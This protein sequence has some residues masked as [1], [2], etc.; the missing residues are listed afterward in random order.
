[1]RGIISLTLLVVLFFCLSSAEAVLFPFRIFTDNGQ[2]NDDPAGVFL[3]DVWDGVGQAKFTFYNK[4]GF[5]CSVAQIY[6]DDG[7]LL[8]IDYIENGPGTLFDRA[9]PGPGNLPAGNTLIPPF[10]ADREFTIGAEA[11]PPENG[12][13]SVPPLDGEWVTIHF[14]LKEGG[15]LEGV[16][17]ELRTGGLRVGIH[18]IAFPDGSS[19]SAILVPEPASMLLL[20]LGAMALLRK[21]KA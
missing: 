17:N 4:S 9:F 11:P 10:V 16:I 5:D 13:N 8:G 3:V 14:D 15:T 19:E 21:R 18:I 1:M 6:F 12:V 20:S 7:S 2:Y